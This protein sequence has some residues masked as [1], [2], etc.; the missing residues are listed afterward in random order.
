MLTISLSQ[1]TTVTGG[2][3][4]PAA[5]PA[6]APTP[7]P[8]PDYD[9]PDNRDPGWSTCTGGFW[10]GCAPNRPKHIF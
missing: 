10:H 1:L 2:Q 6:P 9:E 8:A 3:T 4:A 7:T 5:A